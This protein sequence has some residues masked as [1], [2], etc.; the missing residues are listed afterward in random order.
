[1]KNVSID[2]S[3][4]IDYLDEG[5]W[6]DYALV[7]EGRSIYELTMNAYIAEVDQDGGELAFYPLADA[8][9]EVEQAA[10]NLIKAYVL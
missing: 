7:T 9:V 4:G 3:L 6:R 8:S 10:I 2:E 5:P 1:M